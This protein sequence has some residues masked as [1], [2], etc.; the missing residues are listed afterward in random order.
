MLGPTPHL[1]PLTGLQVAEHALHVTLL[2]ARSRE[3]P[4]RETLLSLSVTGLDWVN[5]LRWELSHQ[6][7]SKEEQMG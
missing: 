4:Q 5:M 2:S 1:G 3:L 7:I 6:L